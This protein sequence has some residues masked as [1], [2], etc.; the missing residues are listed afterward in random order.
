MRLTARAPA[1]P[2]AGR[3]LAF[4]QYPLSMSACLVF[5]E[6]AVRASRQSPPV[7]LP[8]QPPP[9]PSRSGPNS[10]AVVFLCVAEREVG[11]ASRF[12]G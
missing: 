3:R 8:P 4:V 2:Q 12:L 6:C 9:P 5:P 1:R 7:Q 10:E 11:L